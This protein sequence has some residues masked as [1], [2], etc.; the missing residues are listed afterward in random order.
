[1]V[2]Q[3][4]GFVARRREVYTCICDHPAEYSRNDISAEMNE[5]EV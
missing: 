4:D 2:S 3:G 5:L 1:M